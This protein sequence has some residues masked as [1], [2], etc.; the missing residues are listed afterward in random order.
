M[1]TAAVRGRKGS[2]SQFAVGEGDDLTRVRKALLPKRR[3]PATYPTNGQSS[4]LKGP[5]LSEPPFENYDCT[6]VSNGTAV[7]MTLMPAKLL[8]TITGQLPSG[9]SPA[10]LVG[11]RVTA[12]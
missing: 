1:Q 8:P 2:P 6:L 10:E 3:P 9:C 11:T 12:A 5:A 7:T 4:E